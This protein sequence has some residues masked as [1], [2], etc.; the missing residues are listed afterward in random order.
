MDESLNVYPDLNHQQQF[1]LNRM[2]QAKDY[3]I[4]EITER[5][6]RRI[7]AY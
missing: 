7:Y 2:N 5:E 3:F 1:M 4:A 6:L